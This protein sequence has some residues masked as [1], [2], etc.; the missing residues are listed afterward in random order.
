VDQPEVEH[1][2]VA[3]ARRGTSLLDRLD[4]PEAKSRAST[5]PSSGRG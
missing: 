4:V 5:S 1:L 3:Q 2:E